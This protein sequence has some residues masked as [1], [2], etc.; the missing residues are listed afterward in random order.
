MNDNDHST[1]RPISVHE[2][3]EFVFCP[4]AWVKAYEEEWTDDGTDDPKP[5]LDF[6]PSQLYA[7]NGLYDVLNRLSSNLMQL[8]LGTAV[9]LAVLFIGA[10]L[11]HQLR[12]PFAALA[13][14]ALAKGVFDTNDL[15]RQI[16]S[17]RRCLD[18]PR[19]AE[20]QIPNPGANQLEPVD[21]WALLN[22]DFLAKPVEEALLGRN[23]DLTRH[24]GLT[25]TPFRL[26]HNGDKA[27]PG[28]FY[29]PVVLRKV[30][31]KNLDRIMKTDRVRNAAYCHLV[32]QQF[33][34][35]VNSHV[36]PY[37]IVMNYLTYK[38]FAI[39]VTADDRKALLQAFEAV[40]EHRR[41]YENECLLPDEPENRSN[42]A[43]CPLGEPIRY[44][45]GKTDALTRK[46]GKRP[47]MIRDRLNNDYHS[48]CGDRFGWVPPH[49]LV[50]ELGLVLR[51]ATPTRAT[52][53]EGRRS[54]RE[55]LRDDRLA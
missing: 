26:L 14:F 11:S 34:K 21:W 13:A 8:W 42:C 35:S 16:Q 12:Y 51:N 37:G 24:P 54:K 10:R 2:L 52:T 36:A 17:T 5:R 46:Y 3:K 40:I 6:T 19:L 28:D 23:P 45:R 20:P 32:E 27:N 22:A 33:P 53:S 41:L 18:I 30:T 49:R 25:G 4:R 15:L 39:K 31:E 1:E 29:I 44:R 48:Y 50:N 9:G 43:G 55:V 47:F 38:G 7:T